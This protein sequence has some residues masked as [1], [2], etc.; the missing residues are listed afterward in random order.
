[1]ALL[2]RLL[3]K[4]AAHD[5]NHLTSKWWQGKKCDDLQMI[6]LRPALLTVQ[7]AQDHTSE[8]ELLLVARYG[9][10]RTILVL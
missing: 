1:M 6:W 8:P 10:Q 5:Q 7:H 9:T 2:Q 3:I 4:A